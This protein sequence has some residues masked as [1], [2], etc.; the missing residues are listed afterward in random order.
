MWISPIFKRKETKVGFSSHDG[1]LFIEPLNFFRH[2]GKTFSVGLWNLMTATGLTMHYLL[3]DASILV[4]FFF[5][6]ITL[7]AALWGLCSSS[8]V[9]HFSGC[10]NGSRTTHHV[11]SAVWNMAARLR[12]TSACPRAWMEKKRWSVSLKTMSKEWNQKYCPFLSFFFFPLG[13]SNEKKWCINTSLIKI[14]FLIW[15]RCRIAC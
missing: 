2:V 9:S 7:K 5:L 13:L 4:W 3:K 14:L 1:V 8:W 12:P 6:L 10:H 11:T 15:H